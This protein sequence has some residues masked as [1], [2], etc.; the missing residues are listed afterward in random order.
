MKVFVIEANG[1][2]GS[3]L[4]TKLASQHQVLSGSRNPK[5][6]NK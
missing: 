5:S 3:L 4:V 1:R 6:E 2:G